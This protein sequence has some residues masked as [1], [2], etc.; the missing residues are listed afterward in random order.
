VE[1]EPADAESFLREG[2]WRGLNVTIPYKRLAA[3][4]ADTKSERVE[5][6]GVANALVRM[7]DGSIHAENTDVLGFAWQLATFCRR[8]LDADAEEVLSG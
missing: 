2:S 5:R 7:P 4:V 8:H 3:D 1:K 6:I